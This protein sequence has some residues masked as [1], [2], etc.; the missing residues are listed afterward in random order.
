MFCQG[1]SLSP[2]FLQACDIVRLEFSSPF[3]CCNCFLTSSSSNILA[4]L[5]ID[6]CFQGA[7]NIKEADKL[8]VSIS[9]LTDPMSHSNIRQ[10]PRDV[11]CTEMRSIF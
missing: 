2:R 3:S 11:K 6:M 1:P 7:T 4:F 5:L 9:V 10:I 8:S